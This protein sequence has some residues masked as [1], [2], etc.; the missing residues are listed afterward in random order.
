[1]L[2]FYWMYSKIREYILTQ[3]GEGEGPEREG[4]ADE[5]ADGLRVRTWSEAVQ[6][7]V[8]GN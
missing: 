1:M 8:P 5:I 3:V 4:E 7:E 6:C 2:A